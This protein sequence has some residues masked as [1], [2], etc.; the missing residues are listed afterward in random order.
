MAVGKVHEA[1][2]CRVGWAAVLGRIGRAVREGVQ[3]PR[4][5]LGDD[6]RLRK[7]KRKS[8]PVSVSHRSLGL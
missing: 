3:I 7:R 8:W 6:L 5:R 4:S 2:D 1:Y